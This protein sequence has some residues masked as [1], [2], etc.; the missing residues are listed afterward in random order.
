MDSI[1]AYIAIS[2]AII[3]GA[4]SPG[5]SFIIVAKT[6]L[7]AGRRVAQFTA[8]GIGIAGTIYASLAAIGLAAALHSYPMLFTAIKYLGGGYLAYIAVA[9]IRFARTPL[10]E[11]AAAISSNQGFR[12]GF[13]T[14]LSNPKTIVVYAS[15]FAALMP[16][17]PELWLIVAQPLTIG[18]IEVVWYFLVARMFA[19]AAASSLYA[20]RKPV[21]DCLAGGVMLLLA[22]KLLLLP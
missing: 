5:P 11:T 15:V 7:S 9:M 14:Q 4:V 10:D 16:S 19:S 8:L 3:V 13:V 17:K 2:S 12:R 21:I 22:A 1:T 18:L 20:R 6:S